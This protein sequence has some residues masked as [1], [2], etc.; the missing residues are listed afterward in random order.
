MLLLRTLVMAL[1]L[2]AIAVPATADAAA[3]GRAAARSAAAKAT[4]LVTAADV[5]RRHWGATPC[6]GRIKVLAQRQVAAGLSPDSDAWATFDSPLGANNLGAPADSYTNCTIS[7]ARWRWPTPASMLADWD[8]LCTTM[9]HELGHLLGR[10]HESTPRSVMAPL[11]TD[12]SNVPPR[13][14]AARPGRTAR[15]P[16]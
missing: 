7:F 11:F 4:V 13:C 2:V 10:A 1:L 16:R 14:R 3:G 5:A 12:L 6:Q 9:T 8:M 15:V